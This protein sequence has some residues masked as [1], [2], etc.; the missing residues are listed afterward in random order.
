[1]RF[2]RADISP[3]SIA[4]GR[5]AYDELLASQL[6]LALVR[7]QKHPWAEVYVRHWYMQSK[8]LH[9]HEVQDTL[10]DAVDLL[11]F[12]NRPETRDCPQSV[13]VTQDLACAYADIDGPGYARERLAVAAETLG[14][15]PPTYYGILVVVSV[16]V[17]L[18]LV[19]VLSASAVTLN[20]SS[21]KGF[22]KRSSLIM[23]IVR[24]SSVPG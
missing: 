1:M 20:R 9:R 24:S 18:G 13:C 14:P 21:T 5:V 22:S 8:I 4:W 15:P 6:A 19:M 23:A 17:L 12:A 10:S 7:A 16:F 11:E 3:Q 2:A